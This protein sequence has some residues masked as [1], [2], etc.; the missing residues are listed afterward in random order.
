MKFS[1]PT[2]W[3]PDLLPKLKKDGIEEIYG[4]LAYD[5]IGGGRPSFLVPHV[6]KKKAVV[7]IAEAH[8][9]NLKFNYL[10]NTTCMGNSE[11]TISG[12]RKICGLLDWLM[13]AGVDSVT[14]A[15]P[16]LLELIKKRYPEFKVNI[17]TQAGIDAVER[18][19]YWNDLG[20]DK[21]TLSV[22]DVNRNF[23]LLENIRQNVKCEL[24]LI[25]NLHCLYKCPFYK[26]HSVLSAH[27]SQSGHRLN[28]FMIDYCTLKCGYMRLLN[29]VEFIRSLWIRPEDIHYYEEI[30]IDSIKLVDRGMVTEA[31]LLIINAYLNRSYDGNLLDLLPHPTKNFLFNKSSLFHK[32][33]YF[34][35]PFLVNIFRFRSGENLFSGSP[36]YIDNRKLD[37]FLDHF[38]NGNCDFI[39]CSKCT[40]CEKMAKV[41]IKMDAGRQSAIIEKYRDY[42]DTL[43]SS[44]MFR[45]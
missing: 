26:Y 17:S 2:N 31:I 18:A 16:Y 5:Y 10:L 21:L 39:S 28:G 37:G 34:L 9:N 15:I 29:P 25:A 43:I 7:H 3:D 4:K 13:E 35:R 8:K 32:I 27:S 1:V 14:V 24:Q 6:S 11:W 38:I 22:V 33:K 42:L 41:A 45:Y 40:Y 12:Q 19:R 20:A 44:K 30:G 36:I 23:K